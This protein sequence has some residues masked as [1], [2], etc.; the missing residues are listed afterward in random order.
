MKRGLIAVVGLVATIG[1]AGCSGSADG[2]GSSAPSTSASASAPVQTYTSD[3][4]GY[5]FQ[6]SAPF[7]VKSDTT[8]EAETEQGAAESTAVFDTTGSQVG[9]QYRD[10]FMVSVYPLST[11]VD[12]SN[13][14]QAATEI[15]QSVLPQLQQT[16]KNMQFGE[17]ATTDVN[18]VPGYQVDATYEV[19]STPM[20]STIYFLFD[21][22]VEYELLVQATT[23]NWQ[24]LQPAFAQMVDSFTVAP[25]AS[26]SPTG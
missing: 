7:E 16:A 13:I 1:L 23:E 5:S 8:T 6:Y 18:G 11:T 4:Y 9:G 24:G 3:Q 19:E 14:D 15:E 21:G 12:E 22:D 26:G 17:L 25:S 2:G 10:A 20:S